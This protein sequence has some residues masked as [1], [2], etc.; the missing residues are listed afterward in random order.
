MTSWL[1]FA[2]LTP[3]AVLCLL[4]GVGETRGLSAQHAPEASSPIAD[5]VKTIQVNGVALAYVER[6][7]GEPVVLIHGFL[8]DYRSWSLQMSDFSKDFRVITYSMRHRWPHSPDGDVSDVSV[9]ADVADLVALIEK[10]ELAPAHLVGHSAGAGVALRVVRDHPD[11]VRSLVLA[12]PGPF[13]FAADAPPAGP[14]FPPEWMIALRQAYESG[15]VQAALGMIRDAV[16]GQEGPAQPLP[17]WTEPILVDNAW[18]IQL[19]WTPEPEPAP[20]VTCEEARHIEAPTLLLGGDRSP[21]FFGPI[22]DGLQECLPNTERAVLANSSH[23]LELENPSG[24]NE[25]VLEFLARRHD[26]P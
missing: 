7:R 22:L 17:P 23:G 12:E 2:A 16:L 20:P 25:I 21:A 13:A 26:R 18:Q 4:A 11:V 1:R 10:L 15:D 14:P 19:M 5:T 9:A 8:N 6:G 3:V 24:F